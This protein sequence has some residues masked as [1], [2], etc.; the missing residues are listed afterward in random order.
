MK[1][2]PTR[3]L[4]RRA[5]T[6]S[7][8]KVAN[9]GAAHQSLKYMREAKASLHEHYLDDAVRSITPIKSIHVNRVVD[10]AVTVRYRSGKPV[11]GLAV[12]NDN[13][14]DAANCRTKIEMVKH[15]QSFR[16]VMWLL[17]QKSFTGFSNN[18]IPRPILAGASGN[19]TLVSAWT[20]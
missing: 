12:V 20:S 5:R 16:L 11:I 2:C 9:I 17:Q 14:F 7:S 13:I 18:Y 19:A 15:L 10:T 6:S 8:A 4:T 1:G 3:K